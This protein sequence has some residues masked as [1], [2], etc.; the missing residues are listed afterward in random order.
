MTQ[1]QLARLARGRTAT[2]RVQ[3]SGRATSSDPKEQPMAVTALP[4]FPHRVLSRVAVALVILAIAVTT[5]LV[6]LVTSSSSPARPAGPA[7]TVPS[8]TPAVQ[9][10][11]PYSCPRLGHVC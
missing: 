3:D 8:I 4:H 9:A 6:V 10:N 11:G 2:G 5:L 1:I 7:I